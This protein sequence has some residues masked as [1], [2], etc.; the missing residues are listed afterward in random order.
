M[1]PFAFTWSVLTSIVEQRCIRIASIP[2]AILWQAVPSLIILI[3]ISFLSFFT[4]N[5]RLSLEVILRFSRHNL[6][7]VVGSSGFGAHGVFEVELQ[8]ISSV[9]S[10]WR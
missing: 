3:V 9:F 2:F 1:Y 6:L 5:A 8:A 10:T 4:F 7:D